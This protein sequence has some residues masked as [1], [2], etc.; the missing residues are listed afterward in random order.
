MGLGWGGACLT[1]F[2]R[3]PRHRR[4]PAKR[5]QAFARSKQNPS[6]VANHRPLSLFS[7]SLTPAT[8]KGSVVSPR[9]R[10]RSESFECS[11]RSS[12]KRR[13]RQRPPPRPP[14][15]ASPNTT[16]HTHNSPGSRVR[17]ERTRKK[18]ATML[19]PKKNRR[20]VYKF[21][22]KGERAETEQRG[23]R[24]PPSRHSPP[25][26]P[27]ARAREGADLGRWRAKD[28]TAGWRG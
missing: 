12:S 14:S 6:R 3:L 24:P 28:D 19:I 18:Q 11:G 5:A 4:M 17:S 10:L 21:L 9:L 22:F 1:G 20:E 2:R 27:S 26:T 23:S 16:Q 8:A 13:Q 15:R 25:R 7:P